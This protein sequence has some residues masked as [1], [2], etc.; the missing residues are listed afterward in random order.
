MNDCA[1]CATL[2]PILSR[3]I[4]RLFETLPVS[5]VEYARLAEVPKE[6]RTLE[7][8]RQMVDYLLVRL[9]DGMPDPPLPS[10]KHC[11]QL[12]SD[13]AAVVLAEIRVLWCEVGA[14]VRDNPH[15]FEHAL[16]E[17]PKRLSEFPFEAPF[18]HSSTE[19]T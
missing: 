11:W 7:E 3:A 6:L 5:E 15:A 16:L 10:S 14:I 19:I 8:E 17:W 1:M 13:V 18:R 2:R 4:P 9:R 12:Q